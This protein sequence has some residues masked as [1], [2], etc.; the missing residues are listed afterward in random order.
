MK[1]FRVESENG[2]GPFVG[3]GAVCDTEDENT[4]FE[5]VNAHI[6]HSRA[7][8]SPPYWMTVKKLSFACRTIEHLAEWF[9]KE[10][11]DILTKHGYAVSV[12]NIKSVEEVSRNQIAYKKDNAALIERLPLSTLSQ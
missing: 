6:G 2:N 12:Y 1:I 8:V 10:M 11:L 4:Y 3:L 7:H 9:T 5:M